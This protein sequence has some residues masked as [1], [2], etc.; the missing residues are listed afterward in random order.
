M[1]RSDALSVSTARTLSLGVLSNWGICKHIST[2]KRETGGII[3]PSA[4]SRQLSVDRRPLRPY[5]SV[6]HLPTLPPRLLCR[7]RRRPRRALAFGDVLARP[8]DDLLEARDLRRRTTPDEEHDLPSH[9]P[10]KVL[11]RLT[12]R[13]P[14]DLLV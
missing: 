9:P 6:I 2:P 10:G 4:L 1:R 12:D 7:A 14:E 13:P 3:E 8:L 11:R 5:E